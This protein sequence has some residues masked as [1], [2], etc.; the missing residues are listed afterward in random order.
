MKMKIKINDLYAHSMVFHMVSSN[1][2]VA[3]VDSIVQ[4]IERN[5]TPESQYVEVH[6][7]N[8]Y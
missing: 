2:K 1:S 3:L 4:F 6:Y 7:C 5:Q 8:V